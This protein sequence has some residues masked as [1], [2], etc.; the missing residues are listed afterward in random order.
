MEQAFTAGR[1]LLSQKDPQAAQTQFETAYRRAV[2]RDDVAEISDAGYDLATAQL[3]Q[4]QADEALATIG[5][6]RAAL[7]LRGRA[8]TPAFS[9]VAAAALHQLGRDREAM[10]V[11]LP[12]TQSP[13]AALAARAT[14]VLGLAADAS[15][16]VR[17]LAAA[18]DALRTSPH[19]PSVVRQTDADELAARLALR[20]GDEA[21]AMQA[22]LAASA[23]RRTLLDYRGMRVALE[24]AAETARRSGDTMR[25]A[26]Y[27]QQ[28]AESLASGR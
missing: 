14:Y 11:A 16:D 13:D 28:A 19:A 12:A 22:A 1:L 21:A 18:C 23:G 7:A 27:A 5:R 20:R 3:A 10:D 9:L 17:T 24:L 6:A 26:A 2:L 4:N 8:Q 15:G 25:A